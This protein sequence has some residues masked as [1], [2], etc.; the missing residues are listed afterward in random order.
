MKALPCLALLLAPCLA[1]G[2]DGDP[3]AGKAVAGVCVACHG[4]AGISGNPEWP[5]LAGQKGPYLAL[6]LRAFRDGGRQHPLM[7]PIA[8]GLS[9]ADIDNLAAYFS[10]LKP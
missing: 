10:G 7:S 1:L 9:D 2:A 3:H 6:Q 5:N 8:K 4:P